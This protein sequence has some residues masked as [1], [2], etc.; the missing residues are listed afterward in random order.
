M[1]A[2]FFENVGNLQH[3]TYLLASVRISCFSQKLYYFPWTCPQVV[4]FGNFTMTDTCTRACRFCNIKTSKAPPPLDEN[5]PYR[6]AKAILEWGLDYVVLTSVDR[7]DLE[8]GG[9]V[10]IGRTVAAIKVGMTMISVIE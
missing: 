5:E 2:V 4:I 6:V 9:A 7:D 10:H 1:T 8:D 3:V